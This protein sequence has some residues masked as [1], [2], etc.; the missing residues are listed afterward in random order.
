LKKKIEEIFP[1]T[2]V[3]HNSVK[4]LTAKFLETGSLP[5]AHRSGRPPVVTRQFTA[6]FESHIA[7]PEEEVRREGGHELPA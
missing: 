7:K 2:H 4:P 5:E 1:Y 3:Y 6:Y